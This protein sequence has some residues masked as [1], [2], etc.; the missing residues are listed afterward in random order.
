MDYQ[1]NK[2]C[3]QY[4]AA[5]T[6]RLNKR[7]NRLDWPRA[8]NILLIM[9]IGLNIFL[10]WRIAS[11]REVT[12]VSREALYNTVKIL[13]SKGIKFS[14]DLKLPTHEGG[15]YMLDYQQNGDIRSELIDRFFGSLPVSST[16]KGD[17]EV[18]TSGS[19]ELIIFGTNTFTYRDVKASASLDLSD[20]VSTEKYIKNYLSDLGFNPFRFVLD[21]SVDSGDDIIIYTFMEEYNGYPIFNNMVK[22]T[23]TKK[24]ITS[25]SGGYINVKGFSG[26]T[27][28]VMPVHQVLLKNA[29][30]MP[31]ITITRINLGYEGFNTEA[32]NGAAMFTSQSPVWRIIC[33]NGS[34]YYFKAYDGEKAD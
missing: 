10:L 19:R 32:S 4:S 8:K 33:E 6:K 7:E 14:E 21:Y 2:R 28:N 11:N 23:V 24:G 27:R 26:S 29:P 34:I 18:I 16:M 15:M 3:C 9:F 31:E 17:S 1:K 25:V 30:K 20:R 13:E 5:Q 12:T 22:V